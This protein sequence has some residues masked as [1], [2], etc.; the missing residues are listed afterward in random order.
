MEASWWERLTERKTE[1]CSDG[2]GHAQQIFN[3][4]FSQWVG[5][6]SLP[7]VWPETKLW[8]DHGGR[9]DNDDLILEVLCTHCCLHCCWP[10]PLLE[11]PGNS[12]ASLGQSLVG[13]LL[14]SPGSSSAQGFVLSVV[15][16]ENWLLDFAEWKSL[17]ILTSFYGPRRTKFS[18]KWV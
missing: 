17:V 8:F 10:T 16:T 1:S 11:T 6:Y 5:L 3:P 13:S 15:S 7:V 4:I 2:R 18:L 12:Q 9:E 14:L